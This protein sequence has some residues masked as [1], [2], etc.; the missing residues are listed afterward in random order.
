[1]SMQ[2]RSLRHAPDYLPEGSIGDAV[3]STRE[4][5]ASELLLFR[6]LW[7]SG[8]APVVVDFVLAD[9]LDDLV[10]IPGCWGEV[11]AEKMVYTC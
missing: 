1:M 8:D 9:C 6:I 4:H 11:L 10:G 3:P 2:E 7:G 5:F